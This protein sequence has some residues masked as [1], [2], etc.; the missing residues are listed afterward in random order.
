[1]EAERRSVRDAWLKNPTFSRTEKAK[2]LGVRRQTVSRWI[3]ELL[4]QPFGEVVEVI[5][6][7]QAG[8]VELAITRVLEGLEDR[9][10]DVPPAQASRIIVEQLKS[11]GFDAPD[12]QVVVNA[13]AAA[14]LADFGSG[15]PV[16]PDDAEIEQADG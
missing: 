3:N 5:R 6:L 12:R 11:L 4:A 2:E 7:R 14:K 10:V 9:A 1:M 13:G 8:I 16:F 15:P